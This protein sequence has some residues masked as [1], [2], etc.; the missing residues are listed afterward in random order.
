MPLVLFNFPH[1]ELKGYVVRVSGGKAPKTIYYRFNDADFLTAR[2]KAVRKAIEIKEQF[3]LARQ[4]NEAAHKRIQ[5][6]LE[7]DKS[8][9]EELKKPVAERIYLLDGAT[10][11]CQQLL[12][13]DLESAHLLG[14]HKEFPTVEV[15]CGSMTYVAVNQKLLELL[16]FYS[17]S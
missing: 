8:R 4:W 15:D 16:S 9:P 7:Y 14:A 12:Q 6:Y 11:P 2:I 5:L 1:I 3:M 17:C 13:L 10:P